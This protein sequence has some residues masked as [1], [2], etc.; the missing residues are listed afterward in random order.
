MISLSPQALAVVDGLA[1]RHHFSRDAIAHMVSAVADG[2]GQM[3]MFSHPEFGGPGQ[4]MQGGMLM[5]SAPLNHVLNARVDALCHEIGEILAHQPG[6]LVAE[7]NTAW[8][9]AELG[10]PNATGEQ[11]GL[12]YAYF[13]Q[14]RRLVVQTGDTLRVYDTL[15]HRI[16]GLAQQQGSQSR[17][18]VTSQ[19][20]DVDLA[21]LPVISTD[22]LSP[23]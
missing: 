6:R 7:A 13:A 22:R 19:H 1:E 17:F 8:W 14:A 18:T 12:R 16:G 4:W 10:T 15:D 2:D 20:G 5:L 21:S 11:N 23:G 9:P 3:A